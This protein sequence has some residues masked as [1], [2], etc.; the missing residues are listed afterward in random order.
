MRDAF[1]YV[2]QA[3]LVLDAVQWRLEMPSQFDLRVIGNKLK[4]WS[5][6]GPLRFGSLASYK[7]G[8]VIHRSF[9]AHVCGDFH[10]IKAVH[11][12]VV[13]LLIS[14]AT[15]KAVPGLLNALPLMT[16]FEVFGG[17][18][19]STR[20]VMDKLVNVANTLGVSGTGLYCTS[21]LLRKKLRT[22]KF[23]ALFCRQLQRDTHR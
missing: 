4:A 5:E 13:R 20:F 1:S 2:S 8:H 14:D 17:D 6:T 21:C 18:S 22:I 7:D 9:H 19:P 11:G 3:R 10:A 12:S 23:G 15:G 16:G